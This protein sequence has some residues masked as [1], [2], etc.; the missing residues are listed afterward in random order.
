[1]SDQSRAWPR[2]SEPRLRRA[3]GDAAE[4]QTKAENPLDTEAEVAADYL[5][6]LL[7]IADLDGDIDTCI[8]GDRAHV[9]I[10]SESEVL[11]GPHGEV[12][13]ALQELTRLAVMTETGD[14]SRLML[15]VAGYRERRRKELVALTTDAV[16]EVRDTQDRVPLAPMNPFERKIVHDTVAAAGLTSESEGEEPRRHVVCCRSSCGVRA[17]VGAPAELRARD[18]PRALPA[19]RAPH[20]R[21]RAAAGRGPADRPA[22]HGP[23]PD[24][25]AARPDRGGRA[26]RRPGRVDPARL[27]VPAGGAG[28]R[29]GEAPRCSSSGDAPAGRGSRAL[30]GRDGAVVGLERLRDWQRANQRW[31]AANDGCRRDI[32]DRLEAA[33]A[34]AVAGAARHLGG[35]VAVHRLDQRP[36]RHASCW[37]SWPRAARWRSPGGGGATGSGTWRSGSTP[38]SPSCPRTRRC[39]PQRAAAA[40]AGHR[41]CARPGVPGRAVGRRQGGRAGRGGGGHAASGAST[42]L[43]WGSR[44]NG[45]AALLSPFDRLVHDR[46]R[47]VE[48]FE[49]DYQL[50][51]YKPV[52]QA[53]LGLLRA[54]DPVRRP[55]GREAR[56]HRRPQGR[57]AAGGR[58]P[59]GRAVRQGDVRRTY[60]R[61]STTSPAGSG[62]EVSPDG[63]R[64]R[65]GSFMVEEKKGGKRHQ[66]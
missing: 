66:G 58:G 48:I 6:E 24:P 39:A 29:A 44:S 10:V 19:G 11:V 64:R 61:R 50:E 1:M 37:R 27:G 23:A 59:R 31:I 16:H 54:A 65:S 21:T 34:A 20:R 25:A 57:G 53:A 51:M 30:P 17:G 49:F 45:R 46:K 47:T 2:P 8:E 40:G 3:D 18:C 28:R 14:R 26:K 35:A 36:Q 13:D 12:L 63:V 7:D 42:R 22:R 52:A 33:R 15:D 9:S 32:L 41:P 60:A 5:E 55:A 43:S 38:T 62:L 4:A 56:R